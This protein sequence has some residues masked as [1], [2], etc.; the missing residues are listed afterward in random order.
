M[1]IETTKKLLNGTFKTGW[2]LSNA[3][4][5]MKKNKNTEK[6]KLTQQSDTPLKRSFS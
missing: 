5:S 4:A 3:A 2:Q 1:K 6:N